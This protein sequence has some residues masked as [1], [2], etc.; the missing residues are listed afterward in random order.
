MLGIGAAGQDTADFET[1]R[2]EAGLLE[3]A[4]N[5]SSYSVVEASSSASRKTLILSHCLAVV[6][7]HSQLRAEVVAGHH[8]G[9][10]V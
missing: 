6:S 7:E 9:G 3:P 4:S 2:E 1:L 5:G 8:I 10:L